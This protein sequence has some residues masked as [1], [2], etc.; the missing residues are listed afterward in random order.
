MPDPTDNHDLEI[1][2]RNLNPLQFSAADSSAQVLGYGEIS[3]VFQI[4][5]DRSLAYKR[6]PLFE[7]PAAA[8]AYSRRYRR[9]C[10]HLRE[11][12]I[13]LP[14]DELKTVAVPGRPLALYII[15]KQ[16]PPEWFAHHLIHHESAAANQKI[17]H[18]ICQ[19]IDAVWSFNSRN[20]PQLELALDG[21]LSNWLFENGN[22]DSGALLYVDTS[23]PLFRIDGVEQLDPEL[24]LKSA[25]GFL[26]WIIR[27]LF[28]EDVMNRYY[29]HRQVLIDLT[30]NLHKE[31]RGE[32]L[33]SAL[34]I[35]ND[36]ISPGDAPI[37]G[38]EIRRYYNQDK[39]IWTIFL[40]FRRID[41]WL[42][43]RILR[44]HYDF[45][46]PGKIQR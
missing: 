44:Q 6:M 21:Q 19:R 32:L 27:W 36:S 29:D 45:L 15:Q 35:I 4:G 1:F 41:R 33:P 26:R 7:A 17:F 18:R 16:Y 34:K 46:L 40:A 12:G 10:E 20:K 13:Q 42:K 38:D 37:D 3:T 8:E 28:L 23:T 39:M 25:P 43:T 2:E 5:A 30:A 22:V 31:Q 11:A 14:P 9:Y 24:F